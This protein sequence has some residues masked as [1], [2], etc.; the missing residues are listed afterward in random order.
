VRGEV[1]RPSFGAPRH[2]PM[3]NL[4]RNRAFPIVPIREGTAMPAKMLLL[5]VMC[6]LIAL[7][8]CRREEAVYEPLKLG[9]PAA[10][11]PAR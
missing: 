10:E 9:G 1:G 11:R 2:A 3:R 7:S 4:K 5:G 6:A 8:A